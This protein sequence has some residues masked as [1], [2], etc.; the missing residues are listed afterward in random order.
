MYKKVFIVSSSPRKGGNSDTLADEFMRGARE[1]GNSV[2]KVNLSDVDMAFCR[3]CQYCQS[4]TKCALKDGMNELYPLIQ[5]SD[6]LVFATPIYFYGMSGQ[7]K[8]F[9]DRLYPLMPK[10]NSFKRIYVLATAADENESAMDE[11]VKG[12]KEWADCYG[13]F[14]AGTLYG[15]ATDVGDIKNTD[16]PQK[17]Y[18]MGKSI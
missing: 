11:A 10:D 5:H 4:H 8:T 15:V 14:I 2:R 7:L 16:A 3:G 9:L 1:G 12:V 13:V 6:V 17:A 18:L